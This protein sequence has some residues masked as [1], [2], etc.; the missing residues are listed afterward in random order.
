MV[1]E[2]K[3]GKLPQ[4][5]PEAIKVPKA[6]LIALVRKA[7][8]QLRADDPALLPYQ[9]FLVFAKPAAAP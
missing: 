3:E 1:V 6:G 4:G 5:P 9:T 8:F 7:G 2:F